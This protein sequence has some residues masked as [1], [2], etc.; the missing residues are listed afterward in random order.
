MAAVDRIKFS[1]AEGVHRMCGS[2]PV[3]LPRDSCVMPLI[4]QILNFFF[5]FF[6]VVA[7]EMRSVHNE[8]GF[9][10]DVY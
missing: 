2:L 8:R 5:S 10:H 7:L 9:S 3:P 1:I 4:D 6:W